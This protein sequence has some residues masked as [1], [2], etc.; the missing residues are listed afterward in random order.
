MVNYLQNILN[1][2]NNKK[3]DYKGILQ[4]SLLYLGGWFNIDFSFRIRMS[5]H[6]AWFIVNAYIQIYG[7]HILQIAFFT[8]QLDFPQREFK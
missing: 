7:K 2:G 6:Q 4:I 3:E 1:E 5:L 8:K